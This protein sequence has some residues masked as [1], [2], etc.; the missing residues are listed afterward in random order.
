VVKLNYYGPEQYDLG[1]GWGR[2]GSTL[3]L[4]L[5]AEYLLITE[6]GRPLP[7]WGSVARRQLAKQLRRFAAEN[8]YRAVFARRKDDEVPRLRQR[9]VDREM[10]K[11]ERERWNTWDEMQT[12]A[13]RRIRGVE[14]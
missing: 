7:P 3:Y 10:F 2:T 14:S 4:P 5:N 12:K 1:G 9:A 8:A 11:E 6:V 13:E